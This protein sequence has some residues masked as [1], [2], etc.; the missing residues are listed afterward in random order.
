[1]SVL[2]LTDSAQIQSNAITKSVGYAVRIE[3]CV[4]SEAK[5][6]ANSLI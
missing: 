3:T 2:M 6:F 1:M 4:S 5:R